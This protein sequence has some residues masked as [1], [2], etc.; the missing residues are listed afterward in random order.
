LAGG[1]ARQTA[2]IIASEAKPNALTGQD[3]L[4]QGKREA[5]RPGFQIGEFESPERAAQ[6]GARQPW[7][8]HS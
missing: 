4:A 3:I 6:N 8:L 1:S 2:L 5:R 7:F